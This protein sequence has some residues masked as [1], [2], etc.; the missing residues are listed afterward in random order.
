MSAAL[1]LLHQ[2]IVPLLV[3]KHDQPSIQPRGR[4]FDI[5]TMELFREIKISKQ[6][7]EAGKALGPSFGILKDSSLANALK[8]VKPGKKKSPEK[9]L[10]VE[11]LAKL[12]PEPVTRC[13]Q[14]LSEP[15]LLR[16]AISRGADVRFGTELV[17]F[18][19]DD[20]Q[21]KA[22]IKDRKTGDERFVIADYLI[23]CDG[24]KSP[25]RKKLQATTSGPG[26]IA[27]LLNIYFEADLKDF[28]K[29]REFS[30]L[31]I[32]EPDLKG[33]MPAINNS[34][35]WIFHMKFDPEKK[36]TFSEERL[37]QILRKVIGL[38]DLP[39]RIISTAAWCPTARVV[40]NMNYN[41]IFLA[42][43]AAHTM[44]PYGGKGANT[45]VQ[46]VHNLA[47]KLAMVIHGT[48]S[49]NLLNT[50]TAERQPVG[51]FNTIQSGNWT[52]ENGLLDKK[53]A[54]NIVT[55]LSNS[56]AFKLAHLFNLKKL[57]QRIGI[58]KFAGMIGIPDY[59]YTSTAIA[60]SEAGL[61]KFQKAKSLT[62][63][64]G[65]RFPHF[66]IRREKQELST[67]D[68]LGKRFILFTGRY[69]DRWNF[70]I[71]KINTQLNTEIVIHSF[72]TDLKLTHPKGSLHTE[73]GITESG[74]VL[75]RPDGFVAWRA[76]NDNAN[77]LAEFE[78]QVPKLL[79]R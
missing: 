60:G 21:V 67:L 37:I 30:Q 69:R 34:D 63:D 78:I 28:V 17:A 8:D 58:D 53:K 57:A 24:S 25:I 10:G 9:V 65:T 6:I 5:R 44:T 32:D 55:I 79:S 1:F 59:A 61:N 35:R 2:G 43:D 54:F 45:G 16:E 68:L 51:Y 14:D 76:E 40:D 11:K 42:G 49:L 20:K 23:A 73:L 41:R 70:L 38:P 18:E 64:P 26:E 56:I 22:I 33:F 48:A 29:G 7:R 13:T 46:D 47:W 52:D 66:W 3:E 15:I 74:A 4:G 50:Y 71:E 75:V 77:S 27:D 39:I 72:D 19:Q 12:S 62:G 31:I 36:E